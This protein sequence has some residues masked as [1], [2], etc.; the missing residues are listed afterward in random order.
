[1]APGRRKVDDSDGDDGSDGSGSDDSSGGGGGLMGADPAAGAYADLI[2][3]ALSSSV[4][5]AGG[6]GLAAQL[7]SSFTPGG[8]SAAPGAGSVAPT[9]TTG[10]AA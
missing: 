6:L 1:M 9:T 10:G 4:M 2:P 3:Q 7:A 5:S 8:G